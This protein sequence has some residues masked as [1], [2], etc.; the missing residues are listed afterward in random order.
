MAGEKEKIRVRI[1]PSPTGKLHFGTARTALFNLLF[2]KNKGGKFII[3]IEDTDLARS[4]KKYEE[5]ILEGLKWL[6]IESDEPVL[7]QNERRDVYEKYLKKLLE[8]KKAY[9]CYCTKEELEEEKQFMLSQGLAPKYNGRCLNSPP[10]GREPQ[11]IRLRIPEKEVV[12][13]DLIRGKVSFDSGLMGDIAIAKDI[14]TPLYNFA[15]VIDDYESE[16]THVIRGEDHIPN[17]PKQI[18]IQEAL[19]ISSPEY[20]HLPLILN[21]EGGKMSKRYME[22]SLLSF[23]DEGYLPEAMVNFMAFLGWHPKEDKEL[24]SLNEIADEF[25][26]ERVQKG[27]AIFNKEKLDWINAQYVK[28]MEAKEIEEKIKGFIP[29]EWFLKEED[30]FKRA[31]LSLKERLI[32]LSDFKEEARFLFEKPNYETD[33]LLWKETKRKEEKNNL[34]AVKKIVEENTTNR[35][36]KIVALAEE[37]GRGEIYW[38]LR[39][40]LSGKKNSPPPLELLFILGQ[41]ESLK[42]IEEA[43]KKLTNEN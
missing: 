16:I 5:E 2:A 21:P 28:R 4:E 27:G 43:I 11:L 40:A 39:V 17:T 22:T 12:F 34:E 36:E 8:E 7:R 23:R 18:L 30:I 31:I 3:R 19:E 26:I 10:K 37:K 15:V 35:D 41:K 25:S 33:L 29:E 32:K 13:K 20:A 9:F 38:P 1:A 6:G 24:M 14:R 42:R